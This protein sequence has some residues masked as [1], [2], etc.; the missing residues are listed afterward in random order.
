MR[1][2]TI[3]N[4][5]DDDD[6][7]DILQQALKSTSGREYQLHR[8]ASLGEMPQAIASTRPD[9]ILL[10]LHL[11]D[12]R[13]TDTVHKAVR[14]AADI[15]ILV[16]TGNGS[17]QIGRNSIEAGVQDF[18]PKTEMF[19]PHLT[20]SID[21]AIQRKQIQRDAEQRA[22][23]D[24]LTG[25]T[26]RA[27]MMRHLV[28]SCARV[29]RHGGGFALAFLDLDGFKAI[30]DR[31]GHAAGDEVL[32]EIA[33]RAQSIARANDLLCRLGGDE[34][35]FYL[36]GLHTRAKARQAAARFAAVV[37][38]PMVLGP[39][40]GHARLTVSASFGLAVCPKDTLDAQGLMKVA[41][42]A[43]YERKRAKSASGA[44]VT[45]FRP[46]LVAGKVG[47]SRG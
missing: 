21:F 34:F 24:G 19:A 14:Y 3:L 2:I 40:A 23:T 26:N 29:R 46:V 47:A 8:T 36:D 4:V 41:D 39:Q 9:L 27:G 25:L 44:K 35:V 30:N 12:A 37:E 32:I 6:D 42:E 22:L 10:D 20:R 43:M 13:G 15:P 11:P 38:K 28:A 17:E 31:Y 5:E 33:K 45:P 18:I 16:L 1:P 7:A